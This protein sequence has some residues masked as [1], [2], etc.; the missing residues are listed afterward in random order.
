M[1]GSAHSPCFAGNTKG[2]PTDGSLK[3]KLIAKKVSFGALPLNDAY[4]M[5]FTDSCGLKIQSLRMTKKIHGF[6]L[7]QAFLAT[8]KK[9]WPEHPQTIKF[10]LLSSKI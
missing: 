4:C 7:L 2:P 1:T 6:Q 8:H 9:Q 3:Q 10:L 5:E